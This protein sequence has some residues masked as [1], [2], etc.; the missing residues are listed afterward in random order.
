MMA[1]A[2][3]IHLLLE[4]IALLMAAATL[5]LLLLLPCILLPFAAMHCLLAA[6][7]QAQHQTGTLNTARWHAR[8]HNTSP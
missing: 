1:A 5:S 2:I 4:L 3:R 6:L 8:A 7:Q